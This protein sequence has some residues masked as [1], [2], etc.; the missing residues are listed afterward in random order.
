MAEDVFLDQLASS[1]RSL[2]AISPDSKY[3]KVLHADDWLFPECL[4]RMVGV[5][6]RDPNVGIVGSYRLE[7]TRVTLDGIPPSVSII[8]GRELGRSTLIGAAQDWTRLGAAVERQCFEIDPD[9]H[10]GE[11]SGRG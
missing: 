10:V 7:E 1:N 8:P 3:T 5:A 6:E 4:E 11:L 2:R 9:V